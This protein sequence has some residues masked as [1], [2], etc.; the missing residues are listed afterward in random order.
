M[1]F[2]SALPGDRKGNDA[3]SERPSGGIQSGEPL[4]PGDFMS[5]SG[6]AATPIPSRLIRRIVLGAA[7][8]VALALWQ[9]SRAPTVHAQDS[10]A[11]APSAATPAAPKAPATPDNA[12]RAKDIRHQATIRVETDANGKKTVTIEKSGEPESDTA[13]EPDK[14]VSPPRFSVGPGKHGKGVKVD[15]FGDDR[16]F[17]SLSE[18]AHSE[19]ELAFVIFL[20]VAVVFMAPVIAIGLILWYRMR[21]NRMLNETMLK[22]AEKGIVPPAE[23]LGALAGNTP[24]ALAASPSTAPLYEQAKQIR[25]RAVSSDLR[26]GVIMGGIGLGLTLYS[27]F[28]DG[29][30]N[31]LGLV[32][33]FVGI[34]YIVLW[35]FEDRQVARA[36]SGAGASPT[37]PPAAGTGGPSGSA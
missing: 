30:P 24:A 32:L 15:V 4:D 8:L 14:I 31:G 5:P 37:P 25:L 17:D 6:P 23:A 35:W 12:S 34:G 33:L 9:G 36:A 18:F 10:K 11:A 2:P 16:E 29:S 13:G 1:H 3:E 21:K 28:D 19:P 7:F 22:L 27:M 26:K 20:I